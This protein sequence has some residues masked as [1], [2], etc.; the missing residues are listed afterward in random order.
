[1]QTNALNGSRWPDSQANTEFQ[2]KSGEYTTGLVG[3]IVHVQYDI[4]IQRAKYSEASFKAAT[5]AA[6]LD[7]AKAEI[8]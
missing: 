4:K 2:R 1:M 5:G 6:T 7:A 8:V 3:S